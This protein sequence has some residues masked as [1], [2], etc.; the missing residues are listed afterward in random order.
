MCNKCNA[1]RCEPLATLDRNEQHIYVHLLVRCKPLYV[2]AIEVVST[3][4]RIVTLEDK[5]SQLDGKISRLENHLVNLE[6]TLGQ[7]TLLLGKM[8]VK[9][10]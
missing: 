10:G 8:N 9:S 1:K 2:P 3:D 4:E 6:S 7:L 5:V